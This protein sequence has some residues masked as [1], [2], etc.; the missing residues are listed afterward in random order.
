LWTAWGFAWTAP[1][2]IYDFAT[3]THAQAWLIPNWPTPRPFAYP[4]TALLALAP[5][6]RLP[7]WPAFGLWT[8]ANLTVFLYA[9]KQ[10]SS[11]QRGLAVARTAS[12]PLVV[13]CLLVGQAT[14][15]AAGLVILGILQLDSRPR[16]SGV[17]LAVAI[18]IKPQIALL[19]PLA[20]FAGGQFKEMA[21]LAIAGAILAA[22]TIVFFGA[23]RWSEWLNCLSAFEAVVRE[24][25][26]L[27]SQVIAPNGFAHDFHFSH[28]ATILWNAAFGLGGAIIVW[29]VFSRDT[30]A[31]TRAAAILAGGVLMAPYAL[32]FDGA[33][34]V[35]P[36]VAMAVDRIA[37]PGWTLRLF[38]LLATVAAA[39]PYLGGLAVVLFLVIAVA[40]RA[41]QP[42][43]SSAPCANGGQEKV[44]DNI[45]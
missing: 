16:L 45:P 27:M 21:A 41:S 19:A 6:G 31:T 15:M 2:R 37:L 43:E 30:D 17:L 38:G 44:T 23:A 10:L 39:V 36:A 14:L 4:P 20:L 24:T 12:Q 35:A 34:I 7:F 9:G 28:A 1:D 42:G 33:A 8:S 3:I 18:A 40:G 11:R 26:R 25:P 5:L 32:R 22:L 29:R 13:L